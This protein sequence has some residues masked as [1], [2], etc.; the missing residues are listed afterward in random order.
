MEPSNRTRSEGEDYRVFDSVQKKIKY[1]IT[2]IIN[3][4]F[5]AYTTQNKCIP[6]EEEYPK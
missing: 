4:G 1:W 5:Y 6:V 3:N 2:Y